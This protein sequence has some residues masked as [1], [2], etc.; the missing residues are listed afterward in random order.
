MDP[1]KEWQA[2][3]ERRRTLIGGGDV[4]GTM[5]ARWTDRRREAD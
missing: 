2:G 3:G 1:D 4:V 5:H